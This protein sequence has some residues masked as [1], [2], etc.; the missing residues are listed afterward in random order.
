M[1][2]RIKVRGWQT[3]LRGEQSRIASS[4]NPRSRVQFHWVVTAAQPALKEQ[5]K[6][7]SQLRASAGVL[8]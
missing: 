4:A 3:F 7:P 5:V 2:S 6:R 8:W 1:E